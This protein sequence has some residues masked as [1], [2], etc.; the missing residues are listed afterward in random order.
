MSTNQPTQPAPPEDLQA[1]AFSNGIRLSGREWGIVG[2]FAL[3]LVFLAPV[4]WKRAEKFDPGPDYR[5]PYELSQDYWLFERYAH[6]AAARYD[7]L[8]LGDSVIWGQYVTH[9]QTLSHR[10]N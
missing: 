2:L 9:G 8:L 4:A 7:T 3:T 5:L 6:L 1:T 10:L